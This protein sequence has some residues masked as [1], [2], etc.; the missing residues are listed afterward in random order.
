MGLGE[1]GRQKFLSKQNSVCYLETNKDTNVPIYEHFGFK[2][3][4][5]G[6]IPETDVMH[7]A[8]VKQP[9]NNQ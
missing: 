5:K 6:F 2:L 7:F 9:E 3:M 8:M 1:G 4:E